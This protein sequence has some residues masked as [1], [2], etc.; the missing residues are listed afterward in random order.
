MNI[1]STWRSHSSSA[2]SLVAAALLV[3]CASL[4]AGRSPDPADPFE[5]YNRAAF[6]FN[7]TVDRALLKPVA[8]AY[9]WV[10]PRLVQRGV[11]NFFANL[12]DL[13]TAA[14]DLLQ[15]KPTMAATHLGR[16]AV[17]S[18]IGL[19]GVFDPASSMNLPRQ[20]EDFGQTLG[21]WGLA[22]GPYLVL[23]ILGP[24]TVRDT[25]ALPVDFALDP[26]M[27][28]DADS[29]RYGLTAFRLVERRASI[30]EFEKTFDS[31][32]LDRYLFVRDAYLSRRRSLTFDGNPP[33]TPAAADPSVDRSAAPPAAAR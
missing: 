30:L 1:E 18:T 31:A 33:E 5:R 19:L 27:Q 22:S 15:G 11:D 4:P 28:I 14:N 9:A 10:T 26:L 6:S 29:W 16:F 12:S 32:A 24:S 21:V 17:N 20:K 13:P 2:L 3:G 23:P 8:R 7:D 25:A